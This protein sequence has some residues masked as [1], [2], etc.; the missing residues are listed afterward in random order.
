MTTTTSNEQ[1]ARPASKGGFRM[2]QVK[3]VRDAVGAYC[4]DCQRNV[5]EPYQHFPWTW[6]KSQKLH[7]Q[8][9]GHRTIMY[10]L[11]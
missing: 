10:S 9:S 3:R 6:R 7:E 2:V 5:C 1:Q 11:E 4:L 8:G